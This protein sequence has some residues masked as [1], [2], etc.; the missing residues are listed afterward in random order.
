M[1]SPVFVFIERGRRK[2]IERA[3]PVHTTPAT[4][5]LHLPPPPPQS[6]PTQSHDLELDHHY[7]LNMLTQKVSGAQENRGLKEKEKGKG[8]EEKR[9]MRNPK[10]SKKRTI[11]KGAMCCALQQLQMEVDLGNVVCPPT[12]RF[13][14]FSP[15]LL[16]LRSSG[17][18]LTNPFFLKIHEVSHLFI[19]TYLLSASYILG[20]AQVQRT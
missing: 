7:T 6:L 17:K 4:V 16:C 3:E 15:H 13:L 10:R 9:V 1:L 11:D 5:T 14:G 19:P 18:T 20:T 2:G 8:K 12:S